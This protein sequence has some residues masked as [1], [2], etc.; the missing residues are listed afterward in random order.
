M[1]PK[2]VDSPVP[3]IQQAPSEKE[4]EAINA[5]LTQKPDFQKLL[6]EDKANSQAA[7]TATETDYSR[8]LKQALDEIQKTS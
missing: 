7:T 4:L 2:Q 1:P 5:Y 8:Q 6:D 3:K